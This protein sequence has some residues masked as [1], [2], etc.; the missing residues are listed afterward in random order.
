MKKGEK[1]RVRRPPRRKRR[2]QLFVFFLAIEFRQR[3]EKGFFNIRFGEG[4]NSRMSTNPVIVNITSILS[5]DTTKGA[6]VQIAEVLNG[7]AVQ[8]NGPFSISITDP[9]GLTTVTPGSADNTTPTRI[10]ASAAAAALVAALPAGTI[11]SVTVT[12]TDESNQAVGSAQLQILPPAAPPPPVPT[13][14]VSFIPGT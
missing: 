1:Y 6:F 13:L 2:P 9:T 4:V 7:A 5:T 10:V 11:A 3:Q 14:N 8:S 12:V